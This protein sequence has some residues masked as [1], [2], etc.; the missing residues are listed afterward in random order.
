MQRL[1]KL[2]SALLIALSTAVAFT[3][4]NDSDSGSSATD[5]YTALVTYNGPTAGS[6][7][8]EFRN[9][10]DAEPV[11]FHCPAAVN[12][13]QFKA[14]QR[15]IILFTPIGHKAD[16][17]GPITLQSYQPV[18]T[19]T[20]EQA[21]SAEV[22]DAN[23]EMRVNAIN[24]SGH[25]INLEA[26][27]SIYRDRKWKMLADE[28]TTGT[29]TVDLYITTDAVSGPAGYSGS[30]LSSYNISSVWAN[31]AVNAVRVHINNTEPGGKKVF[32]F[33]KSGSGAQ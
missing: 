20:V 7:Y 2:T 16:Q 30:V 9:L 26:T 32:E 4:C 5:N 22:Q 31:P 24:S 18:P 13:T 25:W 19:I 17:S 23:A 10:G 27:V 3:A 33:K 28:S 15:M 11:I 29:G 14:G 12:A 1:T 21:T 8:F 6:D